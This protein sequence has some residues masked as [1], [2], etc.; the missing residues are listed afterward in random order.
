M[1]KNKLSVKTGERLNADKL[2]FKKVERI[3]RI[4]NKCLEMEEYLKA[5]GENVF[6]REIGSKEGT[7]ISLNGKLLTSFGYCDYLGLSKNKK[8]KKIITDHLN[9]NDLGISSS[10]AIAGTS[11]AHIEL[12]KEIA[13]FIGG[14]DCIVF[15]LGYMA[16]LGAI[17]ALVTSKEVLIVDSKSH[18]SILDGCYIS[19]ANGGKIVPYR[20]KNMNDLE[21]KLKKYKNESKLIV[22][23]GVFSMD[24][25]IAPLDKIH[26]LANQY[27]AGV[28][29]D[30][31]HGLGMLGD[32]GAGTVE[33]FKLQGQIDL[34]MGTLSKSVPLLGGFIVG[35]KEVIQY[36]KSTCRSY[37]FCLGLPPY[38]AEAA[39]ES[40]KIIKNDLTLKKRLWDNTK[41]VRQKLINNKFNLSDSETPIISILTKDY[42]KTF[43]LAKAMET[44]GYLVDPI[45]YPGV[46]KNESRIRLVLTA[47]HTEDEIN[48]L[49]NKL[50]SLSSELGII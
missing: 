22:T 40:I 21:K 10:R 15:M 33:H 45:I 39:K 23:D 29:V 3:P 26:E 44:Q 7:K 1:K 28:L 18:A 48:D 9:S 31:A 43:E 27:D 47:Q 24:G 34:I 32:S 13:E 5:G 41:L 14:E 50:S 20:H 30:D 12:E 25:D 4:F 16:N 19:K 6:H 17:P 42:A 38:V 35:K 11:K 37:L 46:K 36:L 8:I 49:V 2:T